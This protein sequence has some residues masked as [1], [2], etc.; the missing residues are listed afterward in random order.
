MTGSKGATAT[1]IQL[2]READRVVSGSASRARKALMVLVAMIGVIAAAAYIVRVAIYAYYYE[3]TDDAFVE[4]AVVQI[5]TKLGGYVRAV[6]V[7]DNQHVS[8]GQVL[9]R[10]DDAD[11]QARL[12]QARAALSVAR[13]RLAEAQMHLQMLQAELEQARAQLAAARANAQVAETERLRYESMPPGAA[14][15][16]ERSNA[17][18]AADAARANVQ[19]AQSK[20]TAAEAA[21]AHGQSRLRTAR[22]ELAVARAALAQAE[23]ELSYTKILAPQ[24]GRVTRKGV[25]PGAYVQPGQA[26]MA[27]VPDQV[28]VVANFK[29]TQLTHMR[30]G[31]PADIRVDAYPGRRFRGHV[32]SIQA[33]TGARFSLLPPE[34]ATGNYVKVVQRVPVKIVFDD[35]PPRQIVLAPGMSVVPR[36]KVR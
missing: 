31:Q 19:A 20:L 7:N 14:S 6:E 9:V 16:Q 11:Q 25:E 3:S 1:H 8:Q 4:S 30:P 36:V 18:A 26:L 33:G 13:S 32:D 17:I 10:L 2:E 24:A 29:E 21:V 27:I 28:W 22:A 12:Q 15:P 34:N 23:L 35:P 5:G